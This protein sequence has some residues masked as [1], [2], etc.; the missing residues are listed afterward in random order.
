M[1]ANKNKVL[2]K[3]LGKPIIYYTF[4]AFEKSPEIDEI[5]VVCPK[6]EIDIF[7]ELIKK[8]KLGK[9]KGVIDGGKERQDSAFNALNHLKNSLSL[10]QKKDLLVIFHN[11]ANLF[12]TE[13]EIKESL[14]EA[15]KWGA[16]VVAHPAKDTIKEADRKKFIVKTLDRSKLWNMQTP[17]TIK[18]NLAWRAFSKAKKEGYVGTDDI[19]LVEK[20]G[21]K[22]KIIEGSLYNFKITTPLDFEIA[23]IILKKLNIK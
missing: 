4:L 13:R 8:Y 10:N 17:Q 14:G 11:G 5:I 9:V 16:S 12:V 6:M 2:L 20:L 21:K 23:G 18:F 19:S 3:I 22:V 7:A 15:K 1:K